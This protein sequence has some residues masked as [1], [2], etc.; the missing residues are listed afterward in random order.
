MFAPNLT[1]SSKHWARQSDN[2]E[3][4]AY[5]PRHDEGAWLWSDVEFPDGVSKRSILYQLRIDGVIK[6]VDE[7]PNGRSVWRT[8]PAL[9]EYLEGFDVER[10]TDAPPNP[11]ESVE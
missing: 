6:Q 3:G 4:L 8:S 9:W 1:A 5:V 10:A 2:Q 11:Y 7:M